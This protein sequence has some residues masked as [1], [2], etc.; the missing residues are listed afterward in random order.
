MRA[1]LSVLG[2]VMVLGIVG[3]LA[4]KQLAAGVAPASTAQPAP[5]AEAPAATPR[6]QVQQYEQAVQGA[7]QQARPLPDD[8]R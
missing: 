1:L 6:Q 2:L 4:K 8:T 7:L 3:L 5:G